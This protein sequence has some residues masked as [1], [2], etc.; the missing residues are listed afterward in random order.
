VTVRVD[1]SFS[2]MPARIRGELE[3]RQAM[4]ARALNYHQTFL[5][6]QLR[7]ILPHD[8]ILIGAPTGIG[9]TDLALSIAA[10]NASRGHRV[11]YFALEAEPDEL[12]RRTKYALLAK[13]AYRMR[14]PHAHDLNYTDWLLGNCEHVVGELNAW[15]DQQ[16]LASLGNLQ[17][18]YRGEK[19]DHA[20]LAR[21]VLEHHKQ[22]DLMVVDHLHYVDSD[23]DNENRGLAEVVKTIRNVSLNVGKPFIV[24][25]H[26]RKHDTKTKQVIPTIHDFHGS[27]NITKICTQAITLERAHDI[28]A[29][30]WYLAPTYMAVLKDRRSGSSPFV[31][32]VNFDRRSKSYDDTYSLGRIKSGKWDPLKVGE[33]PSW[34]RSHRPMDMRKAEPSAQRDIPAPNA[35]S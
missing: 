19:F 27:S 30:K 17:T 26:L 7:A 4:A 1:N 6:D 9:K 21:Y 12:E 34:A 23:D 16:I 14:H 32:V 2:P 29:P 8:L 11:H 31:A 22:S 13:E 25:A 28:E 5:D 33:A 3:R 20:D 15:A 35:S 18:Y 24:V 10:A